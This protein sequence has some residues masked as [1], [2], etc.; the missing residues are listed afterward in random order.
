MCFQR[1]RTELHPI[2]FF[3]REERGAGLIEKSAITVR[4]EPVQYHLTFSII[5]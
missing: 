5:D 4:R 1:Y 2:F 3:F